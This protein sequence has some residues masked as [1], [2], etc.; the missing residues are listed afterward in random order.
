MSINLNGVAAQSATPPLRF[1]VASVK[2][3]PGAV[4]DMYRNLSYRLVPGGGLQGT[5]SLEWLIRI[6]YDVPLERIVGE[7][8]WVRTQR[9]DVDDRPGGTAT[10]AERLAMLRTLIEERFGLVWRRDPNGKQNVYTLVMANGAQR[11][12]P[13][14]RRADMECV[15]PADG[16]RP[17]ASARQLRAGQQVPCGLG[18]YGEGLTAAGNQSIQ[19]IV[20]A[21]RQSLGEEVVDRTNLTGTFDFYVKLPPRGQDVGQQ[22]VSLFTAVQEQLGMKLQRQEITREVFVVEQV[23]QPTAN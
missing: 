15:K 13:G 18:N 1:A 4:E 7:P 16:T 23:S 21:V 10:D 14:I 22:D 6:A 12:G 17:D 5:I 3:V 20:S 11:L 9:F 19:M 2:P 8:S